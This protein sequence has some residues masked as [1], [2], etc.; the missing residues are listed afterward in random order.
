MDC[1]VPDFAFGQRVRSHDVERDRLIRRLSVVLASDTLD[2]AVTHRN[3]FALP[4]L[5]HARRRYG[6]VFGPFAV[7]PRLKTSRQLG[8]RVV[9]PGARS[10]QAVAD[11]VRKLTGLTGKPEPSD[12]VKPTTKLDAPAY[13]SNIFAH[14]LGHTPPRSRPPFGIRIRPRPSHPRCAGVRMPTVRSHLKAS[15]L[16]GL[17]ARVVSALTSGG[18]LGL[19]LDSSPNR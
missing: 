3:Q 18:R 12:G 11:A 9:A 13:P 14:G 19:R 1:A 2:V 4:D 10:G 15:A 8:R 17:Q 5:A 7:L 6:T 16:T